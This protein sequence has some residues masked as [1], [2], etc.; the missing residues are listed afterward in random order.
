VTSRRSRLFGDAVAHE[1]RGARRGRH[2]RRGRWSAR[3]GGDVAGV[4]DIDEY[5]TNFDDVTNGSV[6]RQ[7]GAGVGAGQLDGGLRR[8]DIDEGWLSVTTSPTATFHATIS[9]SVRPSPT[10]GRWKDSLTNRSP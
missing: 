10:S 8:L 5:G 3:R 1:D 9:A 2:V 6:K 4:T 7:H